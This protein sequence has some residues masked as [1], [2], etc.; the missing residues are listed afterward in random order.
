MIA[1]IPHCQSLFS[2]LWDFILNKHSFQDLPGGL[3]GKT[4][5]SQCKESGVQSLVRELDPA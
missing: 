1:V 5:H 4:P 2:R 3:V